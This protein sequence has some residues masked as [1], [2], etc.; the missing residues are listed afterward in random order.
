MADTAT[1]NV[2]RRADYA[3]PAFLIDTVAL[4]FDLVPERTVVRN[5]MRVRRNPDASRASNLELMGE[6]LEFVSAEMDGAAFANAHAHEH[7]LT[8]ENVPD[9]FELTLTSICN[10]AENTTLSGLYVS[11]GNF[12]TQCEAEGFRRITY[13]LD[14][15]D[16]MAT[17]TVTLRAS[18]A[19]YPVLLS[20]G[21]L[22]E[23]GDLPDGRHFA[24]W[25]DPFRKPS[26]LFALVA[27]KLVAL[28]ERV[29]SGSGKEKLLQVWVEPHDLDKTRHAMDSLINSIR[30]D[31]QR[32]GLELDLD[33]FMIVAVSDFNMGAMEN[34]GLNIFNTK[35]VLANPETATDTD[36]A[37][38]EAVVGHE[39]FHNWTGNRVTCRDWFQLSLKEGLTVF[40]DQEFSL[41]WQ[42][43][44]PMKP[45][46]PPSASKTC[47]CC[48]RCSL[49]KTRVRW[50]TRYARK[51]TS[52]S[53]I[54]TR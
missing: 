6:Q 10:P 51:A 35:Y 3:P 36:F 38:I 37:N 32:F 46:A 43:A 9:N 1:P 29:T 25:E 5:T 17:F 16:V 41:T 30:W 39:Y 21:N 12:F 33:R 40:R 54:S 18:K 20:N 27:G 45:H 19:D 13:F 2:I 24:R 11:G 4:E 48:A 49:P 8:L 47:A 23:E 14:R 53:T 7:G 22:L 26:Y 42:A 15:P 31:E 34:K 44:R 28:E 50:R 52:R